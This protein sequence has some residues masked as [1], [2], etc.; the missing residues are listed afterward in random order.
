MQ[1]ASKPRIQHHLKDLLSTIQASVRV[2]DY[3]LRT[4]GTKN[5]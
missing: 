1:V 4:P 3:Y 2:Q 5:L